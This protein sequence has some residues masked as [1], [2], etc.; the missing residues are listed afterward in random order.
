MLD[1]ADLDLRA[2]QKIILQRQPTDLGVQL[3][4]VH[5]WR[6]SCIGPD[7]A[8]RAREELVLPVHDLVGVHVMQLGQLGQRA[9]AP[10]DI[11]RHLGP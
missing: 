9:L 3:T 8:G 7:H 2:G 11:Y 4:Q 5:R 1:Q 6:R 10:D